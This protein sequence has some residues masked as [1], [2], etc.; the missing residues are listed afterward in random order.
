MN[1]RAKNNPISNKKKKNIF[2]RWLLTW[3]KLN[4]GFFC[5]L[6]HLGSN[7]C[8]VLLDCFQ[9]KN[10][11]AKI[12]RHFSQ[13]LG[14]SLK[15]Q[16]TALFT[17]PISRENIAKFYTPNDFLLLCFLRLDLF[18]KWWCKHF[19]FSKIIQIF[20]FYLTSAQK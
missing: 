12:Q 8:Y 20:T 10:F 3:L 11:G 19:N 1:F 16:W 14:Y 7:F 4:F 13:S 17:I 2:Q 5:K 18:L 15:P 9:R 6:T